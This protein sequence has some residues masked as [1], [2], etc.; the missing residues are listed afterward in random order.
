M[1]S[2]SKLNQD[3]AVSGLALSFALSVILLV[4]AISFGAWA[5]SSRQ[6]YKNNVDEK[7]QAAV[8][9]AKQQESAAKDAEFAEAEKSP[10]RTYSGPESFGSI[11]I[12][13]PKTWSAYVNDGG[14]DS[15]PVDGYFYPNVVPGITNRSTPFALRLQV[16]GQS[17][18]EVA[19]NLASQQKNTDTKSTPLTISPYALPKVPKVVGIK[20]SGTLQDKDNKLGTM[21]VLPLRSQTLEV[22]TEGTQFTSDF[23]KY[24]LPNMTFSP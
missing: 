4:A 10:L 9:T 15:M 6:D 14:T 16:V 19:K 1:F 23:D 7:I 12:K 2:M 11:T 20:V 5:F 21:I 13:Y 8:V 22:W 24:I 18:S 17:Y 3:G